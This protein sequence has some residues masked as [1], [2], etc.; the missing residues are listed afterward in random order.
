MQKDHLLTQGLLIAAFVVL[1]GSRSSE[2]QHTDVPRADLLAQQAEALLADFAAEP[3]DTPLVDYSACEN[4]SAYENCSTCE[5]CRS[6]GCNR[7]TLF[8][9]SYG[10]SFSGGPDLDE[11]LVTDRPDFTEASVT[12]GE[13]VSQLEFGYTYVYDNESGESTRTQ[14]FGEA[15]LR[16][17]IFADWLEFRIQAFPVEQQTNAAGIKNSTSGMEDMYVGFKIALTPQEGCLPEMALI[18]Q[19]FV[20][21]GS[22]AFTREEVLPG[23]NWIY[24]W[25][26]TEN[27]ST[28]GSTQVNRA[29]DDMTT[30]AH[31]LFAQSWTVAYS[32]CENLGAYTE[33]FALIRSSADTDRTTHFFNGG[34]T[35]LLSDD[36]Q[37]DIRGGVGLNGAAADYFFGTGLS[38][39]YQ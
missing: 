11:P 2:A 32:L 12:V 9:W 23:L 19:A 17:G 31:L 16:Y 24:A 36:V 29:I 25:E 22:K 26:L 3:S 20:P 15:L 38:I 7:G 10:T 13:G 37:W 8:Q 6:V 5:S 28:A 21:A 30:D 39:R 14:S 34:F 18:P 33:W 1:A 35:Y 27:I 4:C